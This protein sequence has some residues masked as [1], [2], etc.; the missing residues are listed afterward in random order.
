MLVGTAEILVI[1]DT[2]GFKKELED[3]TAPGF[4][5]LKKD[6]E[7]AG[8]DAGAGL[9]TGVNKEA[10]KLESDLGDIGSTGGINLREGVKEGSK[11]LEKDL[12]DLGNV[13][14]LNLRKGVTEETG[15]L[16]DDLE[17]DGEKGGEGLHKGMSGALGKLAGL[18]E[19]T[20]LPLGGLSSGLEKAG[21]AAEHAGSKS[22]GFASSLD[23]MGG[24]ALA[25]VAGGLL[26]V[27]AAG[28]DVGEKMQSA[29]AQIA[30]S[31]GITVASADKIGSAFLGTAGKSEFS[32]VAMANAF[33]GVAGQLKSTEGHALDAGDA[34]K[35]MS[36]AGDLA[37]A[38][39]ID[40]GD[41]TSTVAGIMQAF[42]LKAGD[43]A[44]VSDVLFSASNAAGQ[45][46]DTLGSSLEKV[47][48]KLGDVAPP[49]G[50]IA[51]LLVDMT[52][53]G[54]TGRAAMSS[55]NTAMTGLL[56]PVD[57]TTKAGKA[58]EVE[59]K[60]LGL[61]TFDS[62][63]KFVGLGSIITQ[64][65]PK[66]AAMT[67]AQQI[68]AATTL[69]GAGAA[70]QMIAVI[71][72][73]P[74]AYDKA[75][76]SVNKMGAAHA[77]AA[78]QAKT[79]HVEEQT[80]GAEMTDLAAK[81]GGVLIPIITAMVGAFIKATTFV[82]SHKAV[83]IA[84]A[85]VVT[86]VLGTAIAVF[87]VNKMVS[88][89]QSFMT[90]SGHVKQFASDVQGAVTKVM[91]LFTQ[92]TEAA[93]ASSAAIEE[94]A[95]ASS[96]AV[97]GEATKIGAE[98]EGIDTSLAS[99]A[100][101]SDTAAGEIE[102]SSATAGTSIEG[103]GAAADATAGEVGV[104]EASMAGDATAA[105][106]TIEAD[107]TALIGSFAG[108]DTAAG[109]LGT[110]LAGVVSAAGAAAGAVAAVGT[111][112]GV[113]A[114]HA[115]SGDSN[116]STEA[117]PG[118]SPNNPLPNSPAGAGV[119]IGPVHIGG[120]G[121]SLLNKL[122]GGAKG[123]F[124]TKP[125]LALIGEAGPEMLIP[126]ND[127]ASI[128]SQ[129]TP[130]P[131]LNMT[132][133]MAS[134]GG[135]DPAQAAIAQQIIAEGNH[136][137]ASVTAIQGAL[138]AAYGES[139]FNPAA[140]NAKTGDSGVFQS[141]THEGTAAQIQGWYTGG[142]S[143]QG[144]GGIAQARAG[145]SPG[146]IATDVEA[147]GAPASYYG[148]Y[149]GDANALIAA[150]GQKSA[151]PDQ[152]AAAAG[153]P[154]AVASML[155]TAQALIGTKYTYGGGHGATFDSVAQLKKIGIDC[156]GFVSK[157]LSSGGIG[158]VPTTTAGLPGV[159]GISK[160]AGAGPNAVNI[161]DRGTG[162]NAH[163][164]MEIAGK[165]FMS[166]G[167]KG[168]NPSSNVTQLSSAQAKQELAGGGFQEYHVNL[169]S[170]SA[171]TLSAATLTS[172]RNALAVTIAKETAAVNQEIAGIKAKAAGKGVSA[173]DKT[174]AAG[175]IAE[176][177]SGLQIEIA[178]QKAA[179]ATQTAAQ[180][181]ELS[182]QTSD[183]KTG[184]MTL[185]KLLS[186]IQSGSMKTLQTDLNQAHTTALAKIEHDL[187]HDHSSALASLSA[188]L[189]KVHSE[190][191]AKLVADTAKAAATAAA[192]AA[193]KA[194]TAA[195]AAASAA[196]TGQVKFIADMAKANTDQI[197]DAG[198]VALDIAA[199][200]GLSG[201][202][203]IAAQAQ[204][205]LDQATQAGD[206]AI[207]AA[208]IA[209]DQAADD[210]Q[211]Q[212]DAAAI[213]LA[214]AQAAA[215]VTEAAAQAALNG[216]SAAASTADAATTAAAD[217]ASA[218]ADAAST[219]AAAATTTTDTTATATTT[220][221]TTTTT[222]PTFTFNIYGNGTLTA[223]QLL[224][225]AAWALTVGALPVAPAAVAVAG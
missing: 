163:E 49:L 196:A 36:A 219:A 59:Q 65:H 175:A 145:N 63:G 116:P 22:E 179:L 91:G 98:T 151:T 128:A 143:F 159:A 200:A 170:A 186:D 131:G 27:A 187:D 171:S 217:A 102:A 20:G 138:D 208:Q 150:A 194:A 142:T 144:G 54:I 70:R 172:E 62:A 74:A 195:T 110:A 68:A 97:E 202:D 44:H 113:A 85:A 100:T 77:A 209:V 111:A 216:A 42:Q 45:S 109:T 112:A 79:L 224:Q 169:A 88:F 148:A 31:A 177:K 57:L 180:K 182:K 130:L 133:A 212:Q 191:M 222:S 39:Q 174:A 204:T 80:L 4:A 2:S 197:T 134:A 72:A 129:A 32:G 51:G 56:K 167:N 30:S 55:L 166:G 193:A 115:I 203:L 188:Q 120:P 137:H 127:L 152:A 19:N 101:A 94:N 61:Q 106:G 135:L 158:T 103:V 35:V 124:V 198:K 206:A 15:K 46:V 125:T 66:F 6:A 60:T 10:G 153:P 146:A 75:T 160:G 176:L 84:L 33:A 154:A 157:V 64:L 7:T 173:Q 40:L 38:K 165:Y 90:A 122:F 82:T 181:T 41:A 43:A 9:R 114:A 225:E 13:S 185:N 25:G 29:D 123:G 221:A 168:V 28:V 104:A 14:G 149:T 58:L 92:Q 81:V 52:N 141:T 24:I 214:N 67:Q 161:F 69:F 223:G 3:S 136:L 8:E 99:T 205:S 78:T 23:H 183:A 50:N 76:S 215:Q 71:A 87:T 96:T 37:T 5:G 184:S 218:A 147:G 213:A 105:A 11:G 199:Q 73:G 139:G 18:I 21:D 83:L 53:Q 189:V 210:S 17:R 140:V 192:A 12:G 89:G 155:A 47:R 26:V 164:F 190:A 108:V 95:A 178:Q 211:A 16:A 162:A 93:E 119:N 1:A 117:N 48:S 107:D 201:A 126:V 118:S 220:A 34:L 207:D 156:S 121:G 86:G 132:N